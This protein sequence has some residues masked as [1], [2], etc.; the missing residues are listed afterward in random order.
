MEKFARLILHPKKDRSVRLFHP[1]LFSR[2]VA[3]VVGDPSEGD[4]VEVYSN[5]N[6]YLGT[7]HF[8][9]GTIKVRV[10]SFSRTDAGGDFWLNKIKIAFGRRERIGLINNTST[11]IYRLVHAEGDGLPGLIIDIYGAVAVIQCHTPG[12]N[13]IKNLI[14]DALKKIYGRQLEA[15]YDKSGDTMSRHTGTVVSDGF[16]FGNV[17]E[18]KVYE[19]DIAFY[20]NWIEGQKTGF[21]IDQRENRQ[22]LSKYSQGKTVLNTFAY[23]GGFSLYALKGGATRVDSV[24]SSKKAALLA[25]RNAALNDAADRHNYFSS[26]AFDFLKSSSEKYDIVILDPPAFAKHLS[27]VDKATVGYRNLNK[28]GIKRISPGGL[29]FTFSCSQAIDA[30]LFRKIV[31]QAAAETRRNVNVIYRLSQGPDHPVSLYHPE[32]EYLKGLVLMID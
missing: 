5:E 12:M 26:D 32:G 30:E 6:E 18:A 1:W 11:N 14:A 9:N 13:S 23:S 2:A 10:F 17:E 4:I 8:H 20:V 7:G 28:D 29:L 31:F 19:N 27:A 16:L 24:D 22:L 15:I 25:E 21:F 3:S